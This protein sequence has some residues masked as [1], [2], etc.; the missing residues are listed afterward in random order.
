MGSTVADLMYWRNTQTSAIVCTSLV[1]SLLCLSQFSIISVG[2]YSA[3]LLLC[4]TITLR[5]YKIALKVIHKSDGVN[6]FQ[7]YIEEDVSLSKEQVDKYVERVLAHLTSAT[8]TLRHFFLVENLVDSL[9]FLVLLYLFTYIGAV[10]NGITLLILGV[11]GAFS[12]PLLY[13]LHQAQID[14]YVGLVRNHL[15]QI[16]AKIE[17][18]LPSAKP[19][20][21]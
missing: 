19:K 6:P 8:K 7:V 5:L 11:I 14:E 2:S 1:V 9:K 10:F 3:L 4:A 20:N 18:K 17:T 13:S 16:R 21:E 12:L 15:R